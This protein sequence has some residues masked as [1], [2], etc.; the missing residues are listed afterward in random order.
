MK[1]RQGET[2]RAGETDMDKQSRH[3]KQDARAAGAGEGSRDF[4][5]WTDES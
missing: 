5:G 4:V 3:D 1:A 2:G